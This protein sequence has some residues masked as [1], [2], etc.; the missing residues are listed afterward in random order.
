MFAIVGDVSTQNPSYLKQ[1]KVPYF[2]WAFDD[3]YCSTGTSK[4]DT[5]LYG[6][7][8]NGCL[9]PSDPKVV[10]NSG[11]ASYKYV[12]KETGKK[13]PTLLIFTD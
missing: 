2:G 8:Y 3:T 12:S 5:S 10:A 6:F 1:Q 11:A 13:N 4:P 9:V 7:G